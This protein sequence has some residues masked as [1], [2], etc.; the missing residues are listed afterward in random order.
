MTTRTKGTTKTSRRRDSD[1]G[2]VVMRMMRMRMM[3]IRVMSLMCRV[4]G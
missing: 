4:C 1:E 3:R 2:M